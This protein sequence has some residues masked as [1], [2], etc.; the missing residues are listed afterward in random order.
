MGRGLL[1]VDPRLVVFGA[2]VAAAA[3][4]FPGL[5]YPLG[6][7]E[8][9]FTTVARHWEPRPES[10]YGPYFL[11]RPPIL[12]G[13][14]KVSDFIGGPYFLRVVAAAGC[15]LLVVA[16]AATGR[17]ALRFA[18]VTDI[19]L[20]SRTGAWTAVL[21]AAFTANAMIDPVMAKGEVLG[22]PLVVASF[23]LG[24]RALGRE[25]V[26]RVSLGLAATAGTS[27]ALALGLKQ[28]MA[29]G[30][31][32]GAIL[33]LGARVERRITTPELVRLGAAAL[34]GALVPVLAT[35]GWAESADVR[36]EVL[37]H[38][39]YGFRID[40]LSVVTGGSANGPA[41]RGLLLLGIGVATGM[42]FVL[43]GVVFHAR[44]LS[45]FSA[46]LL[47]ATLSVVVL[48]LGGLWLGGSLWR[49][50]LFVLIPGLTLCAILLLAVRV[51]VARRAR[52]LVVLAAAT[53]VVSS[54]LWA[55]L[56]TA[57]VAPAFE[58]HSGS[59]IAAAA[60]PG[61]TIVVYGGRADLVLASGL[62]SPYPYLWSLPMR[63]L[64]P[65]LEGL[66]GLLAG[67]DAPTWVVMMAP[68]YS[69]D[70]LGESIRPV[71]DARYAVHGRVC[72]GRYVYLLNDVD[73][74]PLAPAC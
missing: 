42:A 12:V 26:D 10:V 29:A 65:E 70:R 45:H 24:L 58:T 62:E 11:D 46:T 16:A 21:T 14:V 18:G 61:D 49:Q 35:V 33:L 15:V 32:F 13:L 69:W 36:L 50:Y 19:R 57:G 51:E 4:R 41:E 34:F 72:R 67:P 60:A 43:A 17:E 55:S 68:G 40:A 25:R 59:A 2:A 63:T 64:D 56:Y 71:L 9:G 5:F 1:D 52:A 6:A 37:W 20:I 39:I 7:D 38:A 44:R 8:A 22:I 28:N 47:V 30:L 53:S 48:D 3:L 27:A 74:P 23:W 31:L 73:R 54:V 66:R